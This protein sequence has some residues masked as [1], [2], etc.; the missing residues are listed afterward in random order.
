MQD[1]SLDSDSPV[2]AVQISETIFKKYKLYIYRAPHHDNR[3]SIHLAVIALL[4]G[5]YIHEIKIPQILGELKI[6]RVTFL[7]YILIIPC[8]MALLMA[9]ICI[10]LLCYSYIGNKY[11]T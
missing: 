2:T 5:L 1:E 4:L 6:S 9:A 3:V 8:C 11:K 7:H 10:I